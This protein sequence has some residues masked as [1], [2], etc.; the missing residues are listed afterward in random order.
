MSI[1]YSQIQPV[2]S[3]QINSIAIKIQPKGDKDGGKKK[4]EEKIKT[5]HWH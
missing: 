5:A 2:D 1:K 4:K 3:D